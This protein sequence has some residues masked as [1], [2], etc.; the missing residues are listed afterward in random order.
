MPQQVNHHQKKI[1]EIEQ[2]VRSLIDSALFYLNDPSLPDSINN[3]R[4]CLES[5]K[6]VL[7]GIYRPVPPTQINPGQQPSQ[8]GRKTWPHG[9][10]ESWGF[11]NNVDDPNPHDH[12]HYPM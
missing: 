4:R 7:Q 9:H 12:P 6:D 8:A 3:A 1:G 5:T 11:V 10:V 2:S